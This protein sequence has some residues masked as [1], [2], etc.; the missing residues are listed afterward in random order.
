MLDKFYKL[1]PKF[2]GEQAVNAKIYYLVLNENEFKLMN[3]EIQKLC[4]DFLK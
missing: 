2:N 4:L 1:R 3:K